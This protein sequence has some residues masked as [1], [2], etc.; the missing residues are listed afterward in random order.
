M[1]QGH[2]RDGFFKAFPQTLVVKQIEGEIS[3]YDL[4]KK[5]KRYPTNYRRTAFGARVE[6]VQRHT[7]G[8]VLSNTISTL[9]PFEKNGRDAKNATGNSCDKKNESKTFLDKT[10]HIVIHPFEE[11]RLVFAV[12]DW[13]AWAG[14]DDRATSNSD[15]RFI[16]KFDESDTLDGLKDLDLSFNLHHSDGIDKPK[17]TLSIVAHIEG[18]GIGDYFE[19]AKKAAAAALGDGKTK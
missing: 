16:G 19:K 5:K 15:K 6:V 11:T 14:V 17:L 8:D 18:D 1:E 9:L 7:N 12:T 13:I 3:Y 2:V 4:K 10:V